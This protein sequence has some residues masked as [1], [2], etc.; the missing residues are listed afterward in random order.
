M[1]NVTTGVLSHV[2]TFHILWVKTFARVTPRYRRILG[3]SGIM[4]FVNDMAIALVLCYYLYHRR[5]GRATY[6]FTAQTHI[7][8]RTNITL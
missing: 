6:A 4:E 2:Y 5:T 1:T 3:V 8:S 7:V